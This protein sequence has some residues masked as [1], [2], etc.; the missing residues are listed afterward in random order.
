MLSLA[1]DHQIPQ[2][3]GRRPVV[4]GSPSEVAQERRVVACLVDRRLELGLGIERPRHPAEVVDDRR[5]DAPGRAGI[6]HPRV[7]RVDPPLRPIS[8]SPDSIAI[9]SP[10]HR[11]MPG[12]L[13]TIRDELGQ[14]GEVRIHLL[15]PLIG[16][17]EASA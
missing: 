15:Q 1:L 7:E 11:G 5:Q 2:E 9:A 12:R 3:A 16:R 8:A 4:E 17:V 10:L 13:E 6:V 14:L